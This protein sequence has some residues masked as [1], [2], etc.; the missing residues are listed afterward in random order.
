MQNKFINKNTKKTVILE[1]TIN[2]NGLDI[3]IYYED[4]ISKYT[5]RRFKPN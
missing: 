3:V 1:Q 2:T 4:N 5:K